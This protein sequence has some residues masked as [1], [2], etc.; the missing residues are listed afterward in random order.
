MR[1]RLILVVGATSAFLAGGCGSSAQPVPGGH[2]SPVAAA[3]GF[4]QAASAHQAALACGYVLPTQ[5]G[6]CAKA[7]ANGSDTLS[8]KGLHFGVTTVSRDKALVTALGTLCTRGAS[9]PCFTNGNRA[10]GQPDA[11]TTFDDAYTAVETGA[12]GTNDP[13]IPC[14]AVNDQW[15]VDLGDNGPAPAPASGATTTP[16]A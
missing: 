1:K 3:A 16:H 9:P 5:T 14:T 10:A 15:Y 4:L 7:F 6:V 11:T 2:G 13:A 8:V 12:S